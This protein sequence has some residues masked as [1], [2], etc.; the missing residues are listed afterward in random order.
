M[1]G[2]IARLGDVG[3]VYETGWASRLSVLCQG[4]MC[5]LAYRCTSVMCVRAHLLHAHSITHMRRGYPVHLGILV[6]RHFSPMA[7]HLN[8][9]EVS[10]SKVFIHINC[11]TEQRC[12]TVKLGEG[13]ETTS[14]RKSMLYIMKLI[15]RRIDIGK[16][17][18]SPQH[19]SSASVYF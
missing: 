15:D 19:L 10:G 2:Q 12:S 11:S 9:C 8:C 13:L 7:E 3:G 1:L 6:G 14:W 4:D 5:V 18:M 17:V 16:D